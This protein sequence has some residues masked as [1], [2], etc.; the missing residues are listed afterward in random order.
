LLAGEAYG[1]CGAM[2][3]QATSNQLLNTVSTRVLRSMLAANAAR[4]RGSFPSGVPRGFGGFP[5]PSTLP[6]LMVIPW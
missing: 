6:V 4:T 2:G 1:V 3:E 5:T